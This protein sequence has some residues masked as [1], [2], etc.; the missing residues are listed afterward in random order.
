MANND[1]QFCAK[2]NAFRCTVVVDALEHY[3]AT[4]EEKGSIADSVKA[5]QC[6]QVRS[7]IIEQA[8]DW[9]FNQDKED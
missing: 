4:L 9:V 5:N 2:L 7:M 8:T 3:R 1:S 6:T